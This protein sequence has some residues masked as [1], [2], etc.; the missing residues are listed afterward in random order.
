M[1]VKTSN[2]LEADTVCNGIGLWLLIVT[3]VSI[4]RATCWSRAAL[5]LTLGALLSRAF[6]RFLGPGLWFAGLL[7]EVPINWL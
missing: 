7:L 1:W 2:F 6:E 5:S 4:G 3:F